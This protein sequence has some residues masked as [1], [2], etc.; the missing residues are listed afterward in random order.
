L[1]ALK[2]ATADMFRPLRL[3]LSDMRSLSTV[4]DLEDYQIGM[5]FGVLS[6]HSNNSTSFSI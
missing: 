3:N 1:E 4:Y 5:I 2:A 6:V